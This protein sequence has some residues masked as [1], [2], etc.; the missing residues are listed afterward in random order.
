MWAHRAL[1]QASRDVATTYATTSNVWQP[2]DGEPYDCIIAG[3]GSTTV[4]GYADAT[5]EDDV[6]RNGRWDAN[7]TTAHGHDATRYDDE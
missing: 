7:A 1:T 6:P 5:A 3:N 4:A 2:H